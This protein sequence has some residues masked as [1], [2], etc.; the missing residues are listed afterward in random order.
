MTYIGKAVSR[1]DGPAKVTGGATL[2]GRVPGSPGLTH[3][4]VVSSTIARGKIT[5]IDAAAALAVPGV[6]RCSR[7]RTGPTRPI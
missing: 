2:R 6:F 1:I 4:V 7:T 3:G 5:R